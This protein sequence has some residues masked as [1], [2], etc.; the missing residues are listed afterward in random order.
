M[1][2]VKLVRTRKCGCG[3]A[4]AFA[5]EHVLERSQLKTTARAI[6]AEI[7]AK[8]LGCMGK[9]INFANGHYRNIHISIGRLVEKTQ[10]ILF[11]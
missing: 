3:R 5:T 1:G 2:F 10:K 9:P 7:K 6:H 4:V 8:E 11:G